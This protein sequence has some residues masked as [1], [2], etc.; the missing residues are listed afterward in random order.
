M[1][2][3]FLLKGS[4]YNSYNKKI[5]PVLEFSVRFHKSALKTN[6]Q[7]SRCLSRVFFYVVLFVFFL[8]KTEILSGFVVRIISI[9]KIY[10]RKCEKFFFHF[11]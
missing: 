2:C 1:K 5:L 3:R 6:L 10:E 4:M 9:F 11:K 7:M 8:S